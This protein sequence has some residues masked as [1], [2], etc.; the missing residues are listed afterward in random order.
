MAARLD[1]LR[2]DRIAARLGGRHGLRGRPGLREH[3]AAAGVRAGDEVGADPPRERDQL[4][5]L[6]DGDLEPL[7]LI[8][9]EHEV[10]AER[11]VGGLPDLADLGAQDG[12][13]G[14]RC[15]ERPDA[16]GLGHRGGEG[17]RG[18]RPDR[19][20]HQRHPPRKPALGRATARRRSYR[21]STGR[22]PRDVAGVP[23]VG[24][25]CLAVVDVGAARGSPGRPGSS[26]R[27]AARPEGEHHLL[28]PA[29]GLPHETDVLAARQPRVDEIDRAVGRHRGPVL[30]P[31]AKR[32]RDP[33]RGAGADV[34][35]VDVT[36]PP[37][38]V[39]HSP[40][41]A[42]LP[43]EDHELPGPD[44]REHN[45]L[46]GGGVVEECAVGMAP[47]AA[48]EDPR[49][50]LRRP[51]LARLG[52]DP[53][54]DREGLGRG[55]PDPDAAAAALVRLVEDDL[56]AVHAARLGVGVGRVQA[57]GTAAADLDPDVV[58]AGMARRVLRPREDGAPGGGQ[59]L[60]QGRVLHRHRLEGRGGRASERRQ[61]HD[62]QTGD[63]DQSDGS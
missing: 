45:G 26:R 40:V 58:D 15:P 17:R 63:R 9:R 2:H 31:P 14:P 59:L 44:G 60:A 34:V 24:A 33:S 42:D 47:E 50:R 6:G 39:P 11:P 49:A 4:D 22:R 61:A 3:E 20:L 56:V 48:V 30:V 43:G 12:R 29:Q 28:R 1:P 52:V 16:S 36:D 25:A 38:H 41:A 51:V 18:R 32:G 5:A 8:E 10:D 35:P 7:L 57:H 27:C 62:G 13:L 55:V 37:A 21:A 53:L 23:R 54:R 19:S 46:P